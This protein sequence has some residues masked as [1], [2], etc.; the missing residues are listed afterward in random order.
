MVVKKQQ[1][2]R[3]MPARSLSWQ[4]DAE[5]KA[6]LGCMMKECGGERRVRKEGNGGRKK[7]NMREE[8]N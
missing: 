8:P 1:M 7:E 2:G 4:E 6:N 5:C 3:W